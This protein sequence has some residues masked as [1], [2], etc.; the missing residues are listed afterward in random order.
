MPFKS[1]V[2]SRGDLTKLNR[3]FFIENLFRQLIRKAY[4]YHNK[5]AINIKNH[6]EAKNIVEKDTPLNVYEEIKVFRVE[7]FSS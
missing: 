1:V 4:G 6:S 7:T 3:R 5:K 2:K